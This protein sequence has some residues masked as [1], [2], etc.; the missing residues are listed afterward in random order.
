MA[1]AVDGPGRPTR[2]DLLLGAAA[3][4]GATALG[5]CGG[6]ESAAPPDTSGA[7]TTG[8]T[9][10]PTS[11]DG[12]TD[13][14]GD[15]YWP[16]DDW[17]AAD[18]GATGWS[19]EGL[20]EVVA[21]AGARNSRSYL[22][23]AGGR[24]LVEEYW[25][26]ASATTTRDVASCQ[27]SV[28]STLVGIARD[29]GLLGLDD[30]VGEHLGPGWSRA[31]PAEEGRIT[32][33]H[34]LTM[35]SGLDPRTLRAVTE[36]GRVW[37]YNTPAY[38]RLRPVLEA[39]TGRGIDE[40]SRTWLFDP[41]GMGPE[42]VWR[43]RAGGGRGPAEG[44]PSWGLAMTARDMARFGLLARRLGSWD[45]RRVVSEA[46][47]REAWTPLDTRSDYGY[48]WWLLGRAEGVAP[49]TPVDW[50]AALGA[51]D[52]KIYVVPSLDLVVARQGPAAA[53][54]SEHGS[55]FDRELGRAILGARA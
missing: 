27:K 32:V 34:L 8:G 46:W 36:P 13:A 52:Q 54:A 4:L 31:A 15:P 38:Q 3:V 49:S 41:I 5:A 10:P 7:G 14:T 37:D 43:E 25:E 21:L 9:A 35:T 22:M 42:T 29:E 2:R 53:E 6:D 40:L 33:R 17:E 16:G 18:P 19:P 1:A 28:V 45:R 30:P 50:V 51:G 12:S 24:I 39:A 48:L 44:D 11:G 23:L 20:A 55:D 47:L 26:G